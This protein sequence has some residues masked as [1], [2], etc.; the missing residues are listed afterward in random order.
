MNQRLINLLV[1]S[2]KE[3]NL[4]F[5]EYPSHMRA[6]VVCIHF[7]V[8]FTSFGL[9]KICRF[10]GAGAMIA[11]WSWNYFALWKKGPKIYAEPY[12]LKKYEV[13]GTIYATIILS[14]LFFVI[15]ICPKDSAGHLP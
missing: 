15:M 14:A 12:S 11:M 13:V 7:V 2:W 5:F 6:W 9:I 4:E 8:F 1:E 10:F 3:D